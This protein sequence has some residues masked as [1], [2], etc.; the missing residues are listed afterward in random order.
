MKSSTVN[1]CS[2][3]PSTS[4]DSENTRDCWLRMNSCTGPSGSVIESFTSAGSIFVPKLPL[5]K[6]TDSLT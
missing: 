3:P 4:I 1:V 6:S 5:R 2:A